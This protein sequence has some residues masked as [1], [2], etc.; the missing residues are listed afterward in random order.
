MILIYI[1]LIYNKS[2][3]KFCILYI[4]LFLKVTEEESY[5]I[6]ETVTVPKREEAPPKKGIS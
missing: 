2:Y 3:T 5:Y 4:L 6:E 1:S